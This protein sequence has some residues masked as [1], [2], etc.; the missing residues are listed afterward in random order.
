MTDQAK[1]TTA[2]QR[3]V[4]A[5]ATARLLVTAPAG[6]GK[7]FSLIRRL[8]FLIDEEE[9]EP[10][11]LLVLSFSRAAVR[12]IR[13]RLVGFGSAAAHVDVRT[14]DSYATWLLSEVTPDG[15]WQRQGFDQRIR[16]ATRLIKEDPN[17]AELIS[18][19]RH[20]VVDEVQ[21]L[22]GDRAELVKALLSTDLGGFTLLGDP[23][24]GIYGFQLD[25]PQERLAG[26]ARLYDDVRKRFRGDLVEI[27][28]EGNFRAREPEARA[29]LAFGEALG[30]V[31][32]PF[33]QLQR[34]LRTVLLSGDSLGTLDQAAPILARMTASTALLCRGN[35]EALLISRRLH[36]LGVPHRLQRAAQDKVLPAWMS[37]LFRELDTKQPTKEAV[38]AVVKVSGIDP[39]VAWGLLRRMDPRRRDD[40]LDLSI[41]R[42]RLLQGDFP[43][44][45]IQQA[46]ESLTV[47][48]I[49]RV[50]GLEFDQV[51]VVDPGDAPD[52]D[53]IEQAER[54]RLLYVAMTR[55]R[56]LLI[57]VK[58]VTKLSPGRLKRLHDG[59]WAEIGFKGHHLGV[60]IRPDDV[61]AEDPAGTV[62]FKGDPRE[63]QSY[64]ASQVQAGDPV[65]LV[66]LPRLSSEDVPRYTLEHEGRR[67][68]VTADAFAKALR[69]LLP[70][71]GRRLPSRVKELRVDSLETVLGREVAGVNAGLGWS[72]VWLRPRITGLGR[73]DW[74]REQA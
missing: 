16:E 41:V 4:E 73:F 66:Q 6:T 26:A 28:L 23:A 65:A 12:E 49:H 1:L 22:V 36:E 32:A 70:G 24:Q 7:T 50:K 8:A 11:E 58:P 5:P 48:T 42:R 14:F 53:P 20:L 61:N 45:L 44:E 55:P 46:S 67:I 74:A 25:D 68:G 21:D 37:A 43:D 60:E 19:V 56:D 57:Y 3:V 47:S 35:K 15:P 2:Q 31:D 33:T 52:D 59:R 38:L 51:I 30:K 71:R 10:A 13:N 18:E 54:A 39:Q 17:A 27:T 72:G 64:L 69:T 9:L 63:I 62:G 34:D 40:A 29:A